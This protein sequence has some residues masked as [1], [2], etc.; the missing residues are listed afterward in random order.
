MGI[1]C[2]VASQHRFLWKK[3]PINFLNQTLK[4][5]AEK[6]FLLFFMLWLFFWFSVRSLIAVFL[7]LDLVVHHLKCSCVVIWVVLKF[8]FYP[9]KRFLTSLFNKNCLICTS[10]HSSLLV[11]A[12]DFSG[13]EQLLQNQWRICDRQNQHS[14]QHVRPQHTIT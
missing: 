11:S 2:S 13:I 1:N 9:W 8:W 12:A 7:V 4:P 6:I 10:F 5:S 14:P 3:K